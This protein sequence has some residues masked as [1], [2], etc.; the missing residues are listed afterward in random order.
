MTE[1]LHDEINSMFDAEGYPACVLTF[2]MEATD[3]ALSENWRHE[4][5]YTLDEER[6]LN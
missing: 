6:N 3:R 1:E 2:G 5:W 4:D